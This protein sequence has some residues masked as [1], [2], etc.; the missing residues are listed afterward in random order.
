M[1]FDQDEVDR[2]L[3]ELGRDIIPE[4]QDDIHRQLDEME[5]EIEEQ[6]QVNIRRRLVGEL[7][8]LHDIIPQIARLLELLRRAQIASLTKLHTLKRQRIQLQNKED[9]DRQINELEQQ[10]L[11][12]NR[13]IHTYDQI[14]KQYSERINEISFI[15]NPRAQPRVEPRTH[16][17]PSFLSR[18]GNTLYDLGH[19]AWEFTDRATFPEDYDEHLLGKK[20]KSRRRR[21]HKRNSL[22]RK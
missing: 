22:K 20:H 1:A 4:P 15:L 14:M 2:E 19:A 10:R 18:V 21:K 12:R 7:Q 8:Q 6:D 11:N 17:P 13:R 9:I 3:A 16:V 5:R